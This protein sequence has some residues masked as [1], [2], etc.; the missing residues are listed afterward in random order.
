MIYLD[1][2]ATTPVSKDVMETFIGVN[3]NFW[4]NPS[5]LHKFGAMAAQVL[6]KSERQILDLLNANNHRVVFTSGATESNNL[7]IKGVAAGYRSRG[8]H[9][10]TTKIE[11]PSVYEV[12]KEL[13]EEGFTL[14]YIDVT[15]TPDEIAHEVERSITGETILVTLMHVNSET[16][17]ILPIKEIGEVVSKYPKVNFHVDAVQSI[18]KLPVDIDEMNIDLLSVSAHKIHGVKGVGALIAGRNLNLQPQIVGGGQMHGL[19]SGTVNVAG[20]ATLAKSMR[21]LMEMQAENFKK[22]R[23]LFDYTVKKLNRINGVQINSCFENQTPYIVNLHVQGMKGETLVHA[24]EEYGVYVSAKSACSS[25]VAKASTVLLALGFDEQVA[26][27][28]IRVSFSH[29]STLE[30]VDV[31][32]DALGKIIERTVSSK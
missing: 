19:R 17:L 10:I 15:K 13:E 28:S 14:T 25:K 20:A 4:G 26:S 1:N 16:G 30:E 22:I 6:I 9:I 24:L 32:L 5:S 11:H 31:F 21:L 12:C 2:S 27:E 8:R 18:G 29:I 23:L 7:T 3:E